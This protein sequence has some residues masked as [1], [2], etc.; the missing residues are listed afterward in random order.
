VGRSIGSERGQKNRRETRCAEGRGR[1][2]PSSIGCTPAY[3]ARA[4]QLLRRATQLQSRACKVVGC[5]SVA[6]K[7]KPR[8]G[9]G[10]IAKLVWRVKVIA[11]LGSGTVSETE[12]ARDRARRLAVPE[13]VGLRLDES[14]QLTAA[15]QAEIVRSQAAVMGERFR[16]CEHPGAKLWSRGYYPATFARFSVMFRSRFAG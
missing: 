14:Q 13:T 1:R 3:C 11:D 10:E 8:C 16:W 6:A 15:I 2:R 7:L 9:V 4:L 5:W 12:V